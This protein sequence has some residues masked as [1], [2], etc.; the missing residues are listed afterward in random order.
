MYNWRFLLIYEIVWIAKPTFLKLSPL[1]L[2]NI[3]LR[4]EHFELKCMPRFKN[5]IVYILTVLWRPLTDFSRVHY[6]RRKKQKIREIVMSGN[7]SGFIV[8]LIQ[9]DY[10]FITKEISEFCNNVCLLY[11]LKIYEILRYEIYKSFIFDQ[12]QWVNINHFF[13]YMM[14]SLISYIYFSR[15][16]WVD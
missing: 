7:W 8:F 10:Y 6:Y 13:N 5:M 14:S 4:K 2:L 1:H 11:F 9:D 12:V 15:Q 3:V 16:Y